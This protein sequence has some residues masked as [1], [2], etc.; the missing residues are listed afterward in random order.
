[1]I[2]TCMDIEA[3]VKAGVDVIRM[4][5]TETAD[6]VR[7]VERE[8]ENVEKVASWNLHSKRQESGCEITNT[9]YVNIK[10]EL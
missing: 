8:I 5:K 3:V 7:E 6:E 10:M 2:P 1:M 4:P 9:C